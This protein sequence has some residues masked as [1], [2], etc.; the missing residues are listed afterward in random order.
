MVGTLLLSVRRGVIGYRRN[1]NQYVLLPNGNVVLCCIVHQELQR[2][3]IRGLLLN[4]ALQFHR[5]AGYKRYYR[6]PFLDILTLTV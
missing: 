5:G 1:L 6:S 2:P 3:G 4:E